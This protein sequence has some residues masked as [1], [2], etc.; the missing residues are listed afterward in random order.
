MARG[1]IQSEVVKM[2]SRIENLLENMLGATHEVP[3]PMSRTEKLLMQIIEN[4]AITITG[5]LTAV[6]KGN[7]TIELK[8]G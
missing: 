3:E 6:D 2:A 4:S 5:T 8:V 7:G 1:N